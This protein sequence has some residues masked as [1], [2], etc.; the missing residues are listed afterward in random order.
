MICLPK[1]NLKTKIIFQF[2]QL[3]EHLFYLLNDLVS[4]KWPNRLFRCACFSHIICGG[5]STLIYSTDRGWRH[6]ALS[7]TKPLPRSGFF[8][9][10]VARLELARGFPLRILSPVCL[11]IPS[12]R[13]AT[14]GQRRRK[15]YSVQLDLKAISWNC[16]PEHEPHQTQGLSQLPSNPC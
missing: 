5:L 9:V 16:L 6:E 4:V 8:M 14:L 15:L 12:H 2:N 11:P 7:N 13:R 1:R 3:V 10:P